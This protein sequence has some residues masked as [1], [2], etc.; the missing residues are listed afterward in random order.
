MKILE[1]NSVYK[2][3]STG[4]IVYDLRDALTK[5]GHDVIIATGRSFERKEL[6][7]KVIGGNI[8]RYFDVI[9]ARIFD[10][11]GLGLKAPTKKLIKLIKDFNPDVVH[12]HNIHGYYVNIRVLFE[13]F[14]ASK[15]KIVWTF[16]DCWPITGHCCYFDLAKCTKWTTRCNCC[17]QKKRYPKSIL[18]DKSESNYII[19]KDLFSGLD[20]RLTIVTPSEWLKKIVKRSFL[21][22]Y[23][24]K[25]IHNGIDINSF[26]RIPN[27]LRVINSLTNKKILLAVASKWGKRKGF[28]EYIRLST[29]LPSEKYRIVMIG[30]S[31]EQQKKLPPTIIGIERTNSLSELSKWYSAADLLLN[32]S[33][34]DNFPTIN[35]EALA[36]GTPILCYDTGGSKEAIDNKSGI[37]VAQGNI[38]KIK[39]IILNDEIFHYKESDCRERALLFDKY[40]VYNCYEELF[41]EI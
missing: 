17:P 36:C 13:F 39:D 41:R 29:M 16:H 26:S 33:L 37:A 28:D 19:K 1:V 15:V 20:D 7:V 38:N 10:N 30:T 35:L 9:S 5:K 14:K 18:L 8:Q 21:S 34:E 6:D 24:V 25:V 23:N 3:G 2:Y 32:L 12:L 22:K 27:D 4:R 31:K 11:A 40:G